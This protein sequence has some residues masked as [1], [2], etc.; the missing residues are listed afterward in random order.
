MWECPVRIEDIPGIKTRGKVHQ[1]AKNHLSMQFEEI[2]KLMQ[3]RGFNFPC[4]DLLCDL[5]SGLSVTIFFSGSRK[6]GPGEAFKGLVESSFFPWD[7]A[8]TAA[9]KSE[10]ARVLY[11]FVRNPLT[12]DLGVDRKP[13]CDITIKKKRKPLSKK[14]L[15]ELEKAPT[16]PPKIDPPLAGSGSTWDVS[17]EGLYY[18]V[19]RLFWNL[20][21]DSAQ[22]DAAEKRFAA[23]QY[24][25]RK[26]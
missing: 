25:W 26:F 8:E 14:D 15:T 17:V 20:A 4:A 11:E 18:G 10:K 5:I 1:F 24:A 19:F 6:V 22:M 3:M 23:G 2:R 16:R 9:G 7:A 12:H 13:G 21:Q